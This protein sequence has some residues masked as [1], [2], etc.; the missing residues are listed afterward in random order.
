M[1]I[2]EQTF[3]HPAFAGTDLA[4]RHLPMADRLAGEVLSLPMGPTL[5]REEQDAVIEAVH[6]FRP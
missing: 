1:S 6:G 3:P 4:D 2:T 5:R